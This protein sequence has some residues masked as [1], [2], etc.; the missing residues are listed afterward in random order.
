MMMN[1]ENKSMNADLN[2][3]NK[4]EKKFIYDKINDFKRMELLRLVLLKLLI[5]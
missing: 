1:V 2:V 5:I 3:K 4:K